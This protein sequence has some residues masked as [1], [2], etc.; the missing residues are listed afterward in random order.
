MKNQVIIFLLFFFSE[1]PGLSLNK[2]QRRQLVGMETYLPSD[3]LPIRSSHSAGSL[4]LD[5]ELKISPSNNAL[6]ITDDQFR[7]M[8]STH[9]SRRKKREVISMFSTIL[10]MN[11]S[12][13]LYN[14]NIN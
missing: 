5:L 8:L 7:T 9:R 1:G 13:C 4:S 14:N 10:C 3:L 11:Y 12:S 6:E 2:R